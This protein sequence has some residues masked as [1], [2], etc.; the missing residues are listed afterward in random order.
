MF[1]SLIPAMLCLFV[2]NR[3]CLGAIDPVRR[4]TGGSGVFNYLTCFARGRPAIH[5]LI[6]GVAQL[7][8]PARAV[9]KS[10]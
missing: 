10:N 6:C 2:G 9:G 7:R 5:L 8:F 4:R 1:S 3:F